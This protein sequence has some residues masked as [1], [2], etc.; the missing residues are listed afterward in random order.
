MKKSSIY[1]LKILSV[2]IIIGVSNITCAA[3]EKRNSY[4]Q[5]E[6]DKA[7]ARNFSSVESMRE[8]DAKKPEWRRQC[9]KWKEAQYSCATAGDIDQCMKIRVGEKVAYM[10]EM[11]CTLLEK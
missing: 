4:S 9:N 6:I 11:W 8:Y 1:T 2:M 5:S 10:G 3:N 7:K